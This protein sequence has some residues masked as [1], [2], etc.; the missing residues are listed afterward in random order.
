MN[1]QLDFLLTSIASLHNVYK[2]SHL[3]ASSEAVQEDIS[4]FLSKLDLSHHHKQEEY[5]TQEVTEYTKKQFFQVVVELLC[6]RGELVIIIIFFPCRVFQTLL[7]V[8][9]MQS[10][11]L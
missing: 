7:L 10:M 3:E 4:P 9:K 1:K 5:F 11:N 8:A 6:L 2:Q